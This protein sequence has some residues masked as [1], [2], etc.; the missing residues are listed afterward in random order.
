MQYLK[1]LLLL[2]LSALFA[3]K[4]IS[5]ELYYYIGPRFAWMAV[6]AA[7]LLSLPALAYLWRREQA[8][9]HQHVS[10]LT[11]LLV[12]LPLALALVVPARPLGASSVANRG[13]TTEVSTS[14]GSLQSSLARS[15]GQR[16][17]LDWARTIRAN[18][19]AHALDGQAVDVVGFVYRDAQFADN[20]FMVTRLTI[21][22]CVA[23]ASAIG[24]VVQTA[25]AKKYEPDSWVRV[26]GKFAAGVLDDKAMPVVSADAITPVEPPQQPYLF[27]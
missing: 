12:A 4:I 11:L 3:Q 1:A 5:G 16:N 2:G 18:P 21:V 10:A 7:V 22:C 14:S 19:D 24:L 20:Q 25:D 26:T 27:P 15:T 8:H 13:F 23:D 6:L 17:V 9:E